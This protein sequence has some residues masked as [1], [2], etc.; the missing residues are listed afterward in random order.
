MFVVFPK[1]EL[2]QKLREP[3]GFEFYAVYKMRLHRFK[4]LGRTELPFPIL[5]EAELDGR[6]ER[7]EVNGKWLSE[8]QIYV[9]D[10]NQS[11]TEH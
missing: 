2:L 9:P 10:E 3:P 1:S 11:N 5:L 7:V 8:R 4:Y 6:T